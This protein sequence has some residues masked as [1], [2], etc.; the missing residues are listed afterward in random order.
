[1]S[2]VA[3]SQPRSDV[4]AL[5]SKIERLEQDLAFERAD[6][7]R[8]R[9][10]L[11][12]TDTIISVKTDTLKSGHKVT[13][14]ALEREL[15]RHTPD[16][17][18]WIKIDN[19]HIAKD[20]DSDVAT[21][22]K[23]LKHFKKVGMIDIRRD[24]IDL[25]KNPETGKKEYTTDYYIKK[26]PCFQQPLAY[27]IN[28]EDVRKQGGARDGAG[29]GHIRR[30]QH[31]GSTEGDAYNTFWC[32]K[33]KKWSHE[34]INGSPEI[35]DELADQ[36]EEKAGEIETIKL[37]PSPTPP[38]EIQLELADL[39]TPA[40]DELRTYAQ[41]VCWR[42]GALDR[43]S[44][45]RKKIP[46]NPNTGGAASVSDPESWGSY[47]QAIAFKAKP[48]VVC[49][50]IGFVFSES[51]PFI[52]I[53]LDGCIDLSGNISDQAADILK[54]ISSYA[55]KSP[56]RSGA[57][58]IVKG[59]IASAIKT[60]EVEMYSTGRYFTFTGEQIPGTP[61]AIETRQAEIDALFS[62]ISPPAPVKSS[63]TELL[64]ASASIATEADDQELLARALKD[65]FFATLMAGNTK[66]YHDGDASRADLAL[67]R[68][69][70]FYTGRDRDRIDRLFRQSGL[71]RP[72]WDEIHKRDKQR[73]PLTYGQI[74]IEKVCGGTTVHTKPPLWTTL[75]AAVM[76]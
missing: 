15:T 9:A 28:P 23:H 35:Q 37:L 58:I 52:G 39:K 19:W 10:A 5:Q 44:G 27:R 57:H 25:G 16:A 62:K 46:I 75:A 2:N 42:Y 31:C 64:P 68:K 24:R 47:E 7:E 60:K 3:I 59:A 36:D 6:N 48:G 17:G 67:V 41:W 38:R 71:M 12:L 66:K 54:N 51:D 33:C 4:N 63:K 22:R 20:S 14:L 74:T 11:R 1:M 40:L 69:L 72:K 61:G 13:R 8:L 45:K 34:P 55:E 21:V 26:K 76:P 73:G 53:D 50:G 30:C 70:D 56:S 49:D 43:A 65:E 29:R 18:G 32:P